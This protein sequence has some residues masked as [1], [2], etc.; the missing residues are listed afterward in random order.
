MKRERA[1]ALVTELL[2]RLDE[3]AGWPLELVDAVYLFGSYARGALDPHDVDIAV[4]FHR[5]EQMHA[6]V[7]AYL[8][9]SARDPRIDLRQALIGRRR[10]IQFQWEASERKE[11]EREGVA[12]LPLWRRGDTLEQ[13]L[14]VLHG[15]KEDPNAGRAPRDDMIEEFEGLD[16]H[17]P[18]PVRHDLVQW[19]D[20]GLITISRLTLPDTDAVPPGR[21]TVMA[22]D[23][24]WNFDSPL[25]RAALS[26]LEHV[27][28]LGAPLEDIELAGELLPTSARRAGQPNEP[29]W[30][31]NWQ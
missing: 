22:I 30:W 21:Q 24:R 28:S 12:M 9:S 5:D 16:R 11:L 26:A 1:T 20:A 4:D 23:E 27:R 18:R 25:R 6:R 3:D 15:I 19:R 14:A 2:Q 7:V 13:A 8:V 31:I 10:G 17:I 29:R